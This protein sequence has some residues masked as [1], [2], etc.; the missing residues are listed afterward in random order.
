MP[1]NA[2][3][4]NISSTGIPRLRRVLRAI[5]WLYPDIGYCQ[6]TGM[7][8]SSM[9]NSLVILNDLTVSLSDT[10]LC[11]F[12]GLFACWSVGLYVWS[13]N[14]ISQD[15]FWRCWAW[16]KKQCIITF[17]GWFGF[18]LGYRNFLIVSLTLQNMALPVGAWKFWCDV[19]RWHHLLV[20]CCG[21]NW[22]DA[23]C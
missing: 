11:F 14:S 12:L 18:R 10:M 13:V 7:V 8:R 20:L 19:M 16:D 5:A 9:G 23:A 2:C 4:C 15:I 21:C 3:F 1:S 22:C 6:G 17:W